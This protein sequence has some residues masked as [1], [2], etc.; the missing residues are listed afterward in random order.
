[1]NAP[2]MQTPRVIKR[3]LCLANSRKLSGRCV[4]G[5][6]IVQGRPGPWIRPVSDRGRQEVSYQERSYEDGSDPRVLDVMDVPLAE[7]RPHEYQQENWLL[8]PRFYWVNAGRLDWNGLQPFLEPE[9][10]LWL[11]GESSGSGLNDRVPAASAALLRSSLLL[12]AVDSLLITVFRPGEAFGNPKRR[13]RGQF[14]LAGTEHW[15]WVTDP[16]YEKRFLAQP[17]G[18]YTLGECCLTIS[19]GE[20]HEGYAY[21]LIAA[22]IERAEIEAE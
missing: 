22:V 16:V 7:P 9:G 3:I 20:P 1:M 11:D 6:E 14:R 21:K 17:D 13:V 10:P 15:L 18:D 8:D 12:V 4:A 5:R 2:E 19:L